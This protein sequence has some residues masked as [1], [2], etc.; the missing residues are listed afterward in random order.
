MGVGTIL[1]ARQLMMLAFG[2]HKAPIIAKA[3]EGEMSAGIA[4][5]FLQEHPNVQVV[6]D[7][8]AAD[9]L[10]RSN[11]PW[12][13]GPVEWDEAKVRKAV[14]W[15]ARKLDK[16]ILTLTDHDYNEEGLQDLLADR[17]PLEPIPCM[18]S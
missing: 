2:E 18:I 15:L 16:A 7:E 6:L 4:A 9:S 12:L 13:L 1:S 14:I 5:S 3:V 11:S 17:G 8:A 10:T